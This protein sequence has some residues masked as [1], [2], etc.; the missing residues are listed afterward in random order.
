MYVSLISLRALRYA[1]PSSEACSIADKGGTPI[2][3]LSGL[4]MQVVPSAVNYSFA[5]NLGSRSGDLKSVK[6]RLKE[7]SYKF[8]TTMYSYVCLPLG[9]HEEIP[10]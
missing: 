4:T 7:K 5:G 2:A 3:G 1:R 6:R 9:N 10:H 8:I